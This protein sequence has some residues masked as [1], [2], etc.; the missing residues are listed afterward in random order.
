MEHDIRDEDIRPLIKLTLLTLTNKSLTVTIPFFKKF[1]PK[2]ALSPNQPIFI[3][4]FHTLLLDNA[5]E[6]A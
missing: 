4:L 6:Y 2:I 5:Q 1:T 3:P